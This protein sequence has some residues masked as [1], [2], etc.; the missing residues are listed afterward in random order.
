MS[1]LSIHVLDTSAGKP[2]AGMLVEFFRLHADGALQCLAREH[3][4]ANGRTARPLIEPADL[5]PGRYQL[6]FHVGAYFATTGH[7]LPEPAFYDL[8][9]I[10]FGIADTTTHYHVPLLVSPWS[11][12][13]YRGS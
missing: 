2:A 13:T 9:P 1:G 12:T 3:T 10:R 11:Y 7:R 8:I 5:Q 6:T 4:D